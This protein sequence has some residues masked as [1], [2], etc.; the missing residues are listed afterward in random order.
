MLA[1]APLGFGQSTP[2]ATSWQ[3]FPAPPPITVTPPAPSP[4]PPP[5]LPGASLPGSRVVVFT[6]PAGEVKPVL[7]TDP[8]KPADELKPVDKDKVPPVVTSSRPSDPLRL[9]SDAELVAEID[10]DRDYVTKLKEYEKRRPELERDY[11]EKLERYRQGLERDKPVKPE[12]PTKLPLLDQPQYQP[13]VL[14]KAGYDPVRALLEP[15]YVVHRRLYFEEKNSDRYGWE[16]GL[17]QPLVSAGVFCKDVLLWPSHLT[18]SLFERYDTSAGK[19]RPGDPVAY[20]LYPP[21]ITLGG[22]LIGAGV[23]IGAGF[24]I[25]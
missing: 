2:A 11:A 24:L 8:V 12:P 20:Y 25:P 9:R 6:K 17:A 5:T 4:A 21:N 16:L 1:L 13:S 18:S 10:I 23:F 22:G 14:V 15:G 7:A 3:K 19:C